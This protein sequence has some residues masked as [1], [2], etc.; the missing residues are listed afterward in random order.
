[1]SAA[2][3]R[4][5]AAPDDGGHL[6]HPELNS[7]MAQR[8]VEDPASV[9]V[10]CGAGNNAAS[11]VGVGCISRGD[12]FASLGTSGVVFVSGSGFLPDPPRAVHAFCHRLPDTWPC[13]SV[14]LSAAASL[15]RR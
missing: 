14:I 15:R 6:R 10:A 12:A 4:E 3:R 8:V 7:M 9:P 5:H 11:A 1:M 13:M 2:R